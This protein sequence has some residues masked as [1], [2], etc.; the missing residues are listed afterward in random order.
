MYLFF[1]FKKMLEIYLQNIINIKLKKENNVMNRRD[2]FKI[3]DFFLS[4]VI[5]LLNFKEIILNKHFGDFLNHSHGLINR[6][7]LPFSWLVFLYRKRNRT[8]L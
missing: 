2:I 8:F 4:R 6:V 5:H 7:I 3:K 1:F